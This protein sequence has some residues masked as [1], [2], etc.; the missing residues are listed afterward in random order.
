M[1]NICGCIYITFFYFN[2]MQYARNNILR[3]EYSKNGYEYSY[4]VLKDFCK[5]YY[6][7]F[8]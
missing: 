7:F 6:S 5:F 8:F 1:S 3:I 4:V 2:G